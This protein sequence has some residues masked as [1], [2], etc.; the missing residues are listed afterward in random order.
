MK[1]GVYL[2]PTLKPFQ[3]KNDTDISSLAMLG[4]DLNDV[5]TSRAFDSVDNIGT[6]IEFLRT[7]LPGFVANVT[8]SLRIDRIVGATIVG[9]WSDEEVI[10]GILE[11]R[12]SVGLYGDLT[13]SPLQDFEFAFEKRTV[14]RFEDGIKIGVLEKDR[15]SRAGLD[16]T[17]T[18][19]N[20]ALRNLDIVRN[21][22]GFRGYKDGDARTYGLLNDPNLPASASV[23]TVDG[24]TTWQDKSVKEI[25]DDIVDVMNDLVVSSGSNFDPFADESTLALSACR[26]QYLNKQNDF[27]RSAMVFIKENYPKCRVEIAPE[28]DGAFNTNENGFYL[29]ADRENQ[30]DSTDSG[31]TFEQI[32]PAKIKMLGIDNKSKYFDEHFSNATAGVMC[33]RP[34]NVIIRTGI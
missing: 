1:K 32:V 15:A 9:N 34:Y 25:C 11:R 22:V 20:T 3:L 2:K 26:Y 7:Q 21:A 30:G 8:Q 10:Q 24:K 17:S 12:G 16:S 18:K 5:N 23:A 14:V 31:L 29:Y 27:G 4:I 28:F 33:K 6:P 19:R 13:A